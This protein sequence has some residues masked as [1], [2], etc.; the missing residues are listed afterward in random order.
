MNMKMLLIMVFTIILGAGIVSAYTTTAMCSYATTTD[1]T[2][3]NP[4]SND[5]YT[6]ITFTGDTSF[7]SLTDVT[8]RLNTTFFY[9]EN[10]VPA[11]K[12]VSSLFYYHPGTIVGTAAIMNVTNSTGTVVG[13]G[14]YTVA[15]NT[16]GLTTLTWS[17]NTASFND[18]TL[19]VCYNKTLVKVTNVAYNDIAHPNGVLCTSCTLLSATGGADFG[20]TY[21][22]RL[23]RPELNGTSYA[24]YW[25]LATR[26]CVARD[27]CQATRTIVFAGYALIALFAIVGAAFFIVNIVGKGGA[28]MATAGVMVVTI[29]GLAI[30]ILVGYL[31]TGIVSTAICTV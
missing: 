1:G 20:Q 23:A 26:T 3:W 24:A 4:M 10:F 27:G 21:S 11:N 12:S 18:T 6:T 30:V 13:G 31:I 25:T 29:I 16:A 15:N 2:D 9:C 19:R 22:V 14:N 28:D 7:N 8:P 5:T 17:F